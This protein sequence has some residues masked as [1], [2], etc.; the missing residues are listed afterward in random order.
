MRQVLID[1]AELFIAH[2]SDWLPRH[3]LAEFMAVGIDAGTHGGDELLKLPT[4]H[5]IKVRP[6]RPKLTGHATGQ[7]DAMARTAILIRHDVLAIL[8][9]RDS[10][11]V[12]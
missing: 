1:R 2:S 8:Q 7:L 5:K 4:L 6:E 12:P 11:A 3:F 9:R 10:Q